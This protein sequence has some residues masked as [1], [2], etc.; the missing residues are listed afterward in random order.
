[1]IENREDEAADLIERAVE[2]KARAVTGDDL[3]RRGQAR[4]RRR[5]YIEEYRTLGSALGGLA[6]TKPPLKR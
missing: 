6:P 4:T 5:R 1:V 2:A 3:E